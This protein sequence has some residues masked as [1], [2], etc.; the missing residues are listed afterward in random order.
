M[1]EITYS[2]FNAKDLSVRALPDLLVHI[3]ADLKILDRGEVIYSEVA[4]PVAELAREL[5]RWI[6][7]LD[8]GASDFAFSS[9]SF[10]EAGAVEVI[11]TPRGW[12]LGSVFVPG[13]RSQPVAQADM[14]TMLNGF[15]AR[16]L[17]D[18]DEIGLD[19]S[20]ILP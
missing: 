17:R 16:V 20:M 4:F 1:A 9:M 14:V 19:S 8:D 6:A 11:A 10:E 2:N 15:I 5:A 12:S 13:V 3:E 18:V 7:S